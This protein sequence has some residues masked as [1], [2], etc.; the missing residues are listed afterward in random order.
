MNAVIESWFSTVKSEEGERSESYAHAKAA[1]FD[2]IEVFDN[3][4]RRHS[5]LGQISPAEF[6][7]RNEEG[8][9]PMENRLERG[10]PQAPHPSSL[11]TPKEKTTKTN[12]LSETVH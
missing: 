6:E 7:R 4:R 2:N 9:D 5:T 12:Q 3:Q 1:L 8:M 11:S 10:F